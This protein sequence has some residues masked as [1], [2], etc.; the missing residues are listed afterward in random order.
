MNRRDLT[1]EIAIFGTP[2]RPKE[3]PLGGFEHLLHDEKENYYVI[4]YIPSDYSDKIYRELAFMVVAYR[5]E[6]IK[7]TQ[8]TKFQIARSTA[9]RYWRQ[10]ISQGLVQC[11]PYEE[12]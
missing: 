8:E 11:F 4:F 9:R 7:D 3:L 6:S 2:C 12:S 5:R 1:K 10:L